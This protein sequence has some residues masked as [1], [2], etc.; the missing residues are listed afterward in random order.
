MFGFAALSHLHLFSLLFKKTQLFF[1]CF[2]QFIA[3]VIAWVITVDS[4][5][6]HSNDPPGYLMLPNLT[7]QVIKLSRCR[8]LTRIYSDFFSLNSV[9][10]VSISLIHLS[11][12]PVEQSQ[13]VSYMKIFTFLSKTKL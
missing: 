8:P 11:S 10:L 4:D 1:N 3:Q 12:F 2:S 13:L 5:I 9:H 7:N 6:S